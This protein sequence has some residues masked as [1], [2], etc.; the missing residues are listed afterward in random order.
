MMRFVDIE[1]VHIIVLI[2]FVVT[3]AAVVHEVELAVSRLAKIEHE[4]AAGSAPGDSALDLS[5]LT[6]FLLGTQ[7]GIDVG[8][9]IG[10]E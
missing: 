10:G 5:D 3:P 1:T 2:T 4:V 8:T 6:D 7:L 9:V